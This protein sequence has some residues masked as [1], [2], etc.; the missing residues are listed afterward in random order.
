ML[1]KRSSMPGRKRIM[2]QPWRGQPTVLLLQPHR[3]PPVSRGS[4]IAKVN[5]G[6][7]NC[8]M[9][10]GCWTSPGE[11]Q[12]THAQAIRM[13]G[14]GLSVS[15]LLQLNREIDDD[16][17]KHHIEGTCLP[18]SVDQGCRRIRKNQTTA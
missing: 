8:S 12:S 5:S 11:P 2:L 7:S 10:K 16:D 6:R 3:K 15:Q 1:S 17:R 14:P 13:P 4:V 18:Q 9:P